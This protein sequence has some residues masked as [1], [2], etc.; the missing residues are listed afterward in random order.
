MGGKKAAAG[1][2]KA[3]GRGRAG[4]CEPE[5]LTD[6]ERVRK[7][8]VW[9]VSADAFV[10]KSRA[11]NTVR[12]YEGV[13]RNYEQWCRNF[14]FEVFPGSVK[15][16][17]CY[18]AYLREERKLKVSTIRARLSAL[19]KLYLDGVGRDNVTQDEGV[20]RMVDG[21]VRSVGTAPVQVKALT[22]EHVREIVAVLPRRAGGG[23]TTRGIRDRALLLVMFAGA[24]RR[25]EVVGFDWGDVRY[26]RGKNGMLLH[27]QKSKTDQ[28]RKGFWVGIGAGRNPETCPVRAL[29]AW[30]LRVGD[31]GPAIFRGVSPHDGILPGRLSDRTVARLVKRWVESIDLDPEEYSGHSPRAGMATGLIGRGAST[32]QTASVTRH[33]SLDMVVRYNRPEHALATNFSEMAGL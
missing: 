21:M 19:R 2:G 17:K 20:L 8:A 4:G 26:P 16:I 15:Q 5:A 3:K 7:L 1:E 28:R 14:R 29:R 31:D 24:F 27:L 23:W 13:W 32:A 9:G 25:S 12:A 18:L 30:R 11:Q 6:A 22:G 10:R 33:K